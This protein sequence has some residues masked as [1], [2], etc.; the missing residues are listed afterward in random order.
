MIGVQSERGAR[1]RAAAVETASGAARLDIYQ[2]DDEAWVVDVD[3]DDGTPADLTGYTTKAQI[4]RTVADSAPTVEAELIT[5]LVTPS[6]IKLE[7]PHAI[8]GTLGGSYVWDLE[9]T[10]PAGIVVT[11]LAGDVIVRKEV[12]RAAGVAR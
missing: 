4:R 11:I 2:G 5:A 7:L 9:I 6:Q 8:T 10:S 3:N 12:T 1:P